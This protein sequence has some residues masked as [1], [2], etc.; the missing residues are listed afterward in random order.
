MRIYCVVCQDGINNIVIPC[1][2]YEDAHKVLAQTI[3]QL[4]NKGA[5]IL[6]H[7]SNYVDL[8]ANDTVI[9]LTIYN[10]EEDILCSLLAQTNSLQ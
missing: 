4:H 1:G 10:Y 2:A 7:N 5:T 6:K 8:V 3:K 9:T